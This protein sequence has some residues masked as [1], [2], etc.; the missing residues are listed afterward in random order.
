MNCCA[1]ERKAE[2]SR[3]LAPRVLV[4]LISALSAG[5]CRKGWHAVVSPILG[6]PAMTAKP[7]PLLASCLAICAVRPAATDVSQPAAAMAEASV[8]IEWGRGGR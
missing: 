7:K 1:A 5:S 4:A 3:I 8:L 6:C 2:F